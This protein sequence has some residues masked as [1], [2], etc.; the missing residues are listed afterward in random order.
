M[1]AAGRRFYLFQKFLLV[2]M[3]RLGTTS[4]VVSLECSIM[5]SHPGIAM[6]RV[7]KLIG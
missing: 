6:K 5:R 3:F 7:T 2:L 4:F 1:E